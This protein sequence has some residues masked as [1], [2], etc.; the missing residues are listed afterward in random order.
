MSFFS[1]KTS[2]PKGNV[3]MSNATNVMNVMYAGANG[4]TGTIN[5]KFDC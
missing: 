1:D 3:C 2:I 5:F 4:F